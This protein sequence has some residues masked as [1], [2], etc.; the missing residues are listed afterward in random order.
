MLEQIGQ[1]N[2]EVSNVYPESV[3]RH[4]YEFTSKD[5]SEISD[6]DIVVYIS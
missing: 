3:D 1:D 5:L 6:S 4:S 2:V